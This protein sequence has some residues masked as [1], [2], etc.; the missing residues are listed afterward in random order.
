MHASWAKIKSYTNACVNDLWAFLT[1]IL[2]S[3]FNNLLRE[4]KNYE[5]HLSLPNEDLDLI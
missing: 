5:S 4:R 3:V 1:F 2:P